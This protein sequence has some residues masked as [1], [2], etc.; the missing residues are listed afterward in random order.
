MT[1]RSVSNGTWTTVSWVRFVC[2]S[3]L[4]P[5]PPPGLSCFAFGKYVAPH[6]LLLNC[7]TFCVCMCCPRRFLTRSTLRY[8]VQS[9]WYT[10]HLSIFLHTNS[11]VELH[12]G[13]RQC[14]QDFVAA[15]SPE[16]EVHYYKTFYHLPQTLTSQQLSDGKVPR[17][18]NTEIHICL[19]HPLT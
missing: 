8:R 10:V 12:H 15:K 6:L 1:R 19:S 9:D 2:V 7:C 14:R 11:P 16:N 3:S 18:V 5:Q 4:K 13:S 17:Q